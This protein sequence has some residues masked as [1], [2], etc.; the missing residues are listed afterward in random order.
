MNTTFLQEWTQP[1]FR[2]A[3]KQIT[4][5]IRSRYF[6]THH[7]PDAD[8]FIIAQAKTFNAITEILGLAYTSSSSS[9]MYSVCNTE[10]Y[11][12]AE[13]KFSVNHFTQDAAGFVYAI[14][15][16]KNENEIILPL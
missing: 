14:C 7:S 1:Q 11:L 6:E 5:F 13:Q 4:K 8:P 2:N 12:D 10:L 3:E 9:A 16:D 15:W